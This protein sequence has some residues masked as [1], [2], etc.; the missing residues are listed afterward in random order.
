MDD[1]LQ[2]VLMELKALRENQNDI[3]KQI[4][5]LESGQKV[6]REDIAKLNHDLVPKV[7][8]IYDGLAGQR[9][10]LPRLDVIEGRVDKL[11]DDVFAIKENMAK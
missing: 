2:Q 3:S 8:V 11:E 4:Q 5:S 10:K 9:E 7:S 6:I 1:V